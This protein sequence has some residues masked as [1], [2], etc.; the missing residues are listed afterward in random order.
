MFT[1]IMHIDM[2][3]YF[4]T[5]E[6]Q[7]NPFLRGKPIGVCAYLSENGCIIAP[8]I[9]AKKSG[10]KTGMRA[11]EA[12]KLCPQIILVENEP[13]KYRSVTTQIF[14]LFAEYTD[15]VEP[16]SIDEAFLD[17]TGFV[18]DYEHASKIAQTIKDR[19]RQ[20]IGE[21]LSCSVGISFTK[22]LAK[23]ASEYKKPDGLTILQNKN[24]DNFYS[25]IKLRDICG[26]NYR[27]EARFQR[28]GITTP[29]QLKNSNVSNI[30]QSLGKYGYYLWANL[31]GH[32]LFTV[33]RG[34]N[35]PKSIGHSYCLPKHTTDRKYLHAIL[36]KLCDKTARRMRAKHFQSRR[37][38]FVFRYVRDGG[39][40]KHTKTPQPMF[41]S[42]CIFEQAVKIFT[43]VQLRGTVRFLA[44]TVSDF[45]P[46]E[47]TQA[48]LFSDKQEKR[49]LM[50]NALDTINNKFGENTILFGNMSGMQ[51]YSPDRIGFRSSVDVVEEERNALSYE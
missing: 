19:I 29:L 24:L 11:R 27:M 44:V 9:E 1:C 3:S 50:Y 20:E 43:S 7:A 12:K 13:A 22:F 45:I 26:I 42:Q 37:I 35:A 49:K 6:Q 51:D 34:D 28:L 5:V 38:S 48:T 39:F 32:D 36:M 41:S 47:T 10:V 33:K 4:A 15:K 23:L 2:N 40:S 21:Y 8:S 17:M 46:I 25:T 14:T 18:S 31:N 30:T 16:F